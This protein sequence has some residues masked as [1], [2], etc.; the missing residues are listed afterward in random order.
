RGKV[1]LLELRRLRCDDLH[2]APRAICGGACGKP[3]RRWC[4]VLEVIC[5]ELAAKLAGRLA[6]DAAERPHEGGIIGIAAGEADLGDRK[7]RTDQE[8]AGPL[9]AHLPEVAAG[10]ETEIGTE[11]A[12]QFPDRC[13]EAARDLGDRLAALHAFFHARDGG[14]HEIAADARAH[15]QLQLLA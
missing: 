13:A 9:H 3:R 5:A 4:A 6:M 10:T 15:P 12:I 1:R 7:T 2:A 14:E 11:G 8:I